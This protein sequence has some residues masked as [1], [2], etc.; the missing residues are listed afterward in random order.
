MIF[1][2]MGGTYAPVKIGH[3]FAGHLT[4]GADSPSVQ[5][6]QISRV[7]TRQLMPVQLQPS[8]PSPNE[9]TR[10]SLI[11][12]SPVKPTRSYTQP[13]PTAPLPAPHPLPQPPPPLPGRQPMPMPTTPIP[14]PPPGPVAQ[15]PIPGVTGGQHIWPNTL[16]PEGMRMVD[17]GTKSERCVPKEYPGSM[18]P[19][20]PPAQLLP[21]PEKISSNV[22]WA[23]IGGVVVIGAIGLAMFLR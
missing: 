9:P 5:S 8:L 1:A 3:N 16:C 12:T 14:T 23:V 7:V 18:P 10:T 22:K 21:S 17:A 6:D 4:L 13:L 20:Q 11:D 19:P 2:D 15:P